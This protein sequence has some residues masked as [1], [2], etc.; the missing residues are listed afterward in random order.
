MPFALYEYLRYALLHYAF[1][2]Y[3]F[4]HY[5]S[6]RYAFLCC[7][8]LRYGYLRYASLCYAFLHY[9]SLRYAF[10]HYTSLC[11]ASLCYAF[12]HY[13]SLHYASLRYG[14]L[15][16]DS[17]H[18]A[19]FRDGHLQNQLVA[20][21]LW[22]DAFMIWTILF[23]ILII[24]FC[25]RYTS[26]ILTSILPPAFCMIFSGVP[27][28]V[29]QGASEQPCLGNPCQGSLLWPYCQTVSFSSHPNLQ[30]SPLVWYMYLRRI[31]LAHYHGSLI[32]S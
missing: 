31:Q 20:I 27:I 6:L 11:Y 22:I 9:A 29:T 28:L 17:L 2:H 5:G 26:I 13:A 8:S 21:Q 19:S 18:Y 10:L 15:G 3:A 30:C 16:Y 12:L 25:H 32:S 7:A 4:L 23:Q 1:L 14:F 24:E